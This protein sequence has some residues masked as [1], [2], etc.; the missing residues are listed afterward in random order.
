MNGSLMSK[1]ST[2]VSI[3]TKVLEEFNNPIL[4]FS[5]QEMGLNNYVSELTKSYKEKIQSINDKLDVTQKKYVDLGNYVRKINAQANYKHYCLLDYN[6]QARAP[7]GEKDDTDFKR[8][9]A[10]SVKR[11]K[12]KCENNKINDFQK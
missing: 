11:Y 1:Y 3:P 7:L 4:I 12:L 6:D 9:Y 8:L 5:L 10:N 2:C